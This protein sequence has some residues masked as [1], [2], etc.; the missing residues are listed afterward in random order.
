MD[1]QG[2]VIVHRYS[3][4]IDVVNLVTYRLKLNVDIITVIRFRA[5]QLESIQT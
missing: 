3:I 4:N 1:L 2:S 5:K